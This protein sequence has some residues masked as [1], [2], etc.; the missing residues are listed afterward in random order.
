MK[1]CVALGLILGISE[2]RADEGAAPLEA[3]RSAIG[4]GVGVPGLIHVDYQR[5]LGKGTFVEL[6]LTPM[7]LHNVGAVSINQEF[8]LTPN[9]SRVDHGIAVGAH[10][11]HVVNI[12]VIG[13][14]PGVRLGYQFRTR[15]F[16]VS[17]S[18]GVVRAVGGESAGD[19][20]TDTRI[21]FWRVKR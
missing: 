14:G 13:G 3:P 21:T 7:L 2:A 12:G 6:G 11:V 1:C 17:L 18:S 8:N 16:G 15:G 19:T 9:S 20:G 10:W 4:G 5:W